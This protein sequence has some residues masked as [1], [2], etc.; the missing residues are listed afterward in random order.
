MIFNFT[1]SSVFGATTRGPAREDPDFQRHP[2]EVERVRHNHAETN[3]AEMSMM[4]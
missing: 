4:Q 1:S 3:E 2:L